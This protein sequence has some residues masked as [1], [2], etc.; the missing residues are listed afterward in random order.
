MSVHK[1]ICGDCI[2]VMREMKND[3]VDLLL[4]DPP[5]NILFFDNIK[6]ANTTVIRNTVFDNQFFDI[7]KFMKEIEKVIKDG[8]SFFIFSSDKQLG[9][10][11][12]Y[13]DKYSK[14]GLRYS[15]TLIW[16]DKLGHPNVR[17]R[18]FSSHVQYIAYGH[19]ELKKK[20]IFNWLGQTKM[21][22]LLEF[23]GCT[24]FEYGKARNGVVGEWVGH[25]TQKPTSLI[26]HLI[27]IASNLS[28][29]ILD[30]F[31]G[32]G[33]TLVAAERLGRNSIGI[34][35]SKEYCE[36]AFQRLKNEVGQTRLDF[37]RSTIEKVGF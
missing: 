9:K 7:Q 5:Y 13:C 12:N 26:Q 20:Y 29:T 35:I 27:S 19:K 3:S 1:I 14:E 4:T 15:N 30:P 2:E 8:A 37:E 28:G 16:Y 24:S 17:K 10:Y 23:N 31:L 25:S 6:T 18:A 32:S 11:I 21:R 36:L 34:E 22:N 33:T